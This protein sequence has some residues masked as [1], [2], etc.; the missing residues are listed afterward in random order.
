MKS[1]IHL[2]VEELPFSFD[3]NPPREER[4]NLGGEKISYEKKYNPLLYLTP[5]PSHIHEGD[6]NGHR[7]L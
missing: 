1:V 6:H 7:A 5:F 2:G 3:K 4:E